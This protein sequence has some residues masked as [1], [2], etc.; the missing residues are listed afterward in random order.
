M[1]RLLL[2]VVVALGG[3]L[4]CGLAVGQSIAIDTIAADDTINLTEDD[5]N[6]AI[7]GTTTG[8]EA[9]QTVSISQFDAANTGYWYTVVTGSATPSSAFNNGSLELNPGWNDTA[10]EITYS[11][12][13][14]ET[15]L[16]GA[17]F[18]MDIWV[19]SEYVSD[20]QMFIQAYIIDSANRYSSLIL[21]MAGWLSGDAWNTLSLNDINN[22]GTPIYVESGFDFSSVIMVGVLIQANGKPTNVNSSLRVDNLSIS[23]VASG[24][25][26]NLSF[27]ASATYYAT[28]N[29]DGSWSTD[30][31]ASDAQA[32]NRINVVTAD[33]STLGGDPAVQAN[34]V[35]NHSTIAPTISIDSVTGDN[36]I[37]SSEDD[38]DINITGNTTTVEDGNTVTLSINGDTY[39]GDVTSGAWSIAIPAADLQAFSTAEALTADITNNAGDTANTMQGIGA[40]NEPPVV[41]LPTAPTVSEDATD[42]AIADDI[43]ISD[44]ESDSQ[45]I[46]LSATGGTLTLNTSGLSFSSGD[47]TNDS[48]MT[49]SGSLISVNSALDSLTYTPTADFNGTNAGALQ[50]QANDG[51]GGADTESVSFDIQA[52]NDAP[53]I[54]GSPASAVEEDSSYSFTPAASD[55]DTGDSLIFSASGIPSWATFNT[56]NGQLS[57]TPT[58]GDV[59][60]YPNIQ[61]GVSDGTATTSLPTF[62]ITVSNTNDAPIISGTPAT[63][64]AQSSGY[65]FTPSASDEDAGDALTFTITNQPTWANFDSATGALSGTPGNADVGTTSNIVIG[66]NDGTVTVNLSSFN[67]TVTNINDAPLIT[68]P[69]TPTVLENDTNVALDNSINLQDVDGDDQ[70]VTLTITGGTVSL[71]SAGLSFG[72]GDGVDDASLSFT[73]SLADINSA[74]DSM[75]YTPTLNLSGSN[76]GGIQIQTNDG[77]GASDDQTLVFDITPA[78]IP[79]ITLPSPPVVSEDDTSVAIDD[80]IEIS[81]S[82]SDP[83]TITISVI[84]GT[85]SLSTSGLSFSVGDGDQD[86]AMTFSGSLADVNTALDSMTFDPASDL[87]GTNAGSITL[88]AS[89]DNGSSDANLSFDILAVNDAPAIAL[90]GDPGASEDDASLN[91]DDSVAITDVDGDAQSVTI[92]VTGGTVSL[93]TSGLF[94]NTGDGLNDATVGFSGNLADINNALDS[95]TFDAT[96]NLNGVNAAAI[97]IDA[98]DGNGGS[99]SATLQFDIAP[100]NDAPS[101]SG[102]PSTSV[103]ED[104]NYSFLPVAT[105]IDSGDSLTFT[106]ANQPAWASFNTATGAL[107]GTPDNSDVGSY[108]NIQ[109]SVSD[110]VAVTALPSFNISVINTNDAPVISGSPATN[111]TQDTAYNFVPTVSDADAGDSLTFSISNLPSWASFNTGN[112]AL[113]GIPGNADV[114]TY[115]NIGISVTDGQIS[116]SLAS[117]SISVSNTNDA[118]VITMPT[119]PNVAEN[120]N[121]VVIDDSIHISDDDGDQQTVSLSASGGTLSITPVGLS[122]SLGSGYGDANMT[123]QG[124]LADINAALDSLTFTPTAN[125][126]GVGAASITLNTSDPSAAMDSQTIVFDISAGTAPTITLPPMPIVN[127]DDVMVS[128]DDSLQISDVDGDNQSVTLTINGG[129]LSID[130][131]GLTFSNGDGFYDQSMTFSGSLAAI[132]SAL[133]SL[134]FNAQLNLHG[135][136]AIEI[137]FQSSDDDG[138]TSETLSIDVTPIN[139]APVISGLTPDFIAQNAPFSFTPSVV[140]AE[141][142]TLIFAISNAPAWATFDEQTGTLSGTPTRIGVSANIQ[143]SVSDGIAT[144][145]LAP[146]NIT[147]T[148]SNDAPVIQGYPFTF[149][150]QNSPYWFFPNA[151]DLDFD[152]LTF[153]ITNQPSWADFDPITGRLTGTPG[154]DDVGTYADIIISVSDGE[155]SASLSPFTLTVVNI[156]DAPIISGT[157]ANNVAAGETYQFVPEAYDADGDALTYYIY[158]KPHWAS[159]DPTTGSLS[160]TPSAWDIGFNYYV[161]IWVSDGFAFGYLPPFLI[162]VD[163]VQNTP[164]TAHNQEV[165]VLQ[166]KNAQLMLVATDAEND[167]LDYSIA[168]APTHG[169]LTGNPP[170]VVYHP[171][172]DFAGEDSFTFHVEDEQQA[173]HSAVV[174]IRVLA[175]SDADGVDDLTDTDDD[176]DSIPDDIEGHQDADGDGIPNHLDTDSD[177]DGINDIDE[178]VND[179]DGDGIADYLDHKMDEDGDNIPDFVEGNDDPD[180]DGLGNAFDLDSDNDGIPDA[181]DF[182]LSGVDLDADGID[183][184]LDVDFNEGNDNDGDGIVDQITLL[185]SDADGLPNYLDPDSDNDGLGDGLENQSGFRDTDGDGITDDFDIGINPGT[186]I[187]G[188]GIA[189]TA[190][191]ADA[192][193]DGTPNMLDL[194]SDNDGVFDTQ[195]AGVVDTDNDGKADVGQALLTH[196]RDSDGDLIPDMFDLDSDNDGVYD[197]SHS[198]AQSLDSNH[199]GRIDSGVD[200]DNDGIDDQIDNEVTPDNPDQDWDLDGVMDTHD[201]DDDNDGIPDKIEGQKDTDMD[202]LPNCLDRDSDNDGLS[203]QIE[204]GKP[205]PSQTDADNDGLDDAYDPDVIGS[206]DQDGDGIDDAIDVDFTQ[207]ADLNRDGLDDALYLAALIDSDG[208]TIPDAYDTDSDNDL[209]PDYEESLNLTLTGLDSDNDGIDDGVDASITGGQDRNLDGIDDSASILMDIDGDGLF[210]HQDPDTDGD[211]IPDRLENADLN[212]DGV[213]DRLQQNISAPKENDKKSG[214][215]FSPLDLL[216]LLANALWFY[217][218]RLTRLRHTRRL[219]KQQRLRLE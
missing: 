43:H 10:D 179:S 60:H 68:L 124:S 114:G 196:L 61:I 207:G 27:A 176:G 109:I 51:A 181:I 155:A 94:F 75:T 118:P 45:T 33:V 62:S 122:F 19:P 63:S 143:I 86:S 185:D 215:A 193:G 2:S 29:G 110:G 157:P 11:T 53:N 119:P 201:Q 35:L 31:P 160:G 211:R 32:L 92:S 46:T 44:T 170:N 101:L 216:L 158:N 24:V 154:N 91:F 88:Q 151:Y 93:S 83:Q 144:A 139:D 117:F 12:F 82:D 22:S 6:V 159:F 17:N 188:D 40:V 218:H 162:S 15:G 163:G 97:Q 18:S 153:A 38:S 200:S 116:S 105:D 140:D 184:S 206:G 219:F 67:L 186:D 204:N 4:S 56:S 168:S 212:G 8:I 165:T 189:D 112:G 49:F 175:D 99:Q 192:D 108:S 145:Y 20:G 137:T 69:V 161:S 199:D 107:T 59:G 23:N 147:V 73:G 191:L 36:Y 89:D 90:P 64:I 141:N 177:N 100:A 195:E 52:V 150:F 149:V 135:A 128:L 134:V 121:A 26:V 133:D 197:I 79:S 166:N 130:Q 113:S 164:P 16:T 152:P 25:P 115:T 57:G 28:V 180:L 34:R 123:F 111:A 13:L 85:V 48:S 156:N 72:V 138:T 209:L 5:N 7:S 87:N 171:D 174:I 14:F 146:F 77:N 127:E 214:G 58:N 148:N 65:S 106:I 76:A 96:P 202:G 190:A 39:S 9:G 41:T 129:T 167:K 131:S 55:I 74:L 194:D 205:S 42:V 80:S 47:G 66:V 30:M 132:N 178:G 81:D 102:T 103:L 203:D 125:I 98:D 169:R 78:G 70:S 71:S 21:T 104:S 187:N 50:I 1:K 3:L 183:D 210:A 208:D 84:G 126:S 198:P 95:L 54:S 37:D 172:T 136:G 142:D 120:A 213:I 173:S 182:G 217:Q